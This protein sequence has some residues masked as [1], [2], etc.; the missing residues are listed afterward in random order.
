M[1]I[2]ISAHTACPIAHLRTRRRSWIAA[3]LF[4]CLMLP[5]FAQVRPRPDAPPESSAQQQPEQA[6]VANICPRFVLQGVARRIKFYGAYF[7]DPQFE[8]E[9]E[10]LAFRDFRVNPDARSFT[11]TIEAKREAPVGKR[12]LK[13]VGQSEMSREVVFYV[14]KPQDRA[15]LQRDLVRCPAMKDEVEIPDK[16]SAKQPAQP[17]Q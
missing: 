8:Y 4:L 2:L 16:P 5:G 11:V 9:G 17:P 1:P 7:A 6:I 14:L 13:L 12:L 3:A 15:L 10:D